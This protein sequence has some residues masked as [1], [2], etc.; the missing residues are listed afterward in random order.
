MYD[1]I[2]QDCVSK[3]VMCSY[4]QSLSELD[5]LAELQCKGKSVDTKFDR[6]SVVRQPNAQR[7]PKPS[8]LG[9]NQKPTVGRPQLQSNQSRVKVLPNNR[10]VKAKK[11]QVE[12]HPRIPSVSNKIKS[13]NAYKDSLNSR[14]LNAN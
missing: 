13:V 9:V 8:V 11:T 3:D 4:L 14:T 5:S 1:K 2:L 6:P 12:V 7:I 10:Q